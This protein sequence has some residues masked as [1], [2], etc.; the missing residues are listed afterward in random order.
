MMNIF[1]RKIVGWSVH[2]QEFLTIASAL[3]T[4][5]CLDEKIDQQQLVLHSDNGVANERFNNACY[6]RK[7]GRY[8]LFLKAIR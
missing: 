7:T 6:T 8:A 2:E 5:T 4:Q 3:I 1:S